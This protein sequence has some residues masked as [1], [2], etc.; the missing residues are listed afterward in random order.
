MIN[1]TKNEITNFLFIGKDFYLLI[2]YDL[3]IILGNEFYKENAEILSKL[4]K[5]KHINKNTTVVISGSKGKINK[6]ITS[7]EASL[8]YDECLKLDLQ[9]NFI[10]EDKATNIKENLLF[11]KNILGDLAKFEH[12]LIIGK[13]FIGRRALM[14]ADALG[15]PLEKLD[16]YGLE[17]KI[18]KDNWFQNKIYKKRILEELERISKYT[19]NNDLKL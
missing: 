15:Y 6:D 12:I 9:L 11:T 17:V 18:K 10:L 5:N 7:T 1:D 8:I 14:C 16:F 4:L 3:V 19:L 2:N 13:A